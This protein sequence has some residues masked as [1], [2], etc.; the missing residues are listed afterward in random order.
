MTT[1]TPT[2]PS[3]ALPPDLEPEV[4][5]LGRR[6]GRR[7]ASAAAV[8]RAANDRTMALVAADP[9]LRAAL[10]RLVD[11]APAC[12]GNEELRAH[13]AAYL[14]GIEDPGPLASFGSRAIDSRA[15]GRASG[16][17][18]ATMVRQM[19]KRFIVGET[20]VDAARPIERIWRDGATVTVD[21]LGEATVTEEEGRAYARRCD[22]ALV[23]LSRHAAGW[24]DRP[25][26]EA[27]SIG[28]IPRVNLSVKVTALTPL[29]RAAAPERG[30]ADAVGRLR[31]LMRRAAGLGAHLHVDM[32]SMDSREMIL[33]LVLDLLA[34]PEFAA[35]PSLGL[36][37][38]AYLR[39]SEEMLE[40][41]LA[42]AAAAERSVPLTIRLVKGAYWDH[43]TIEAAQ[44]GW[45]P[46]VWTDKADSDRCFERLTRR[47]L[48]SYPL[49]RT[50]IASHNLRSVA[51]AAAYA[52]QIGL[53]PADFEIQVLRGLG[54]DLQ[55]AVV[56]AG[57]RCRV[58]C[59]VGDMVSG[60]AYLVRRLLENTS[61][62]SFLASRASGSDLDA[63]LGRP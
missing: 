61:N 36:V 45:A 25:A 13:L 35:G 39:D 58:Y 55:E 10:F 12:R 50:A 59:P 21:L 16:G 29:V 54:D 52:E 20:I 32:E 40:R 11:V 23:E 28:P 7:R 56:E 46:P 57:L 18:A 33:D 47:L 63:L 34:E 41:I 60:M 17:V 38:Q 15:L 8:K 26:V 48:D 4:L 42:R 53:G 30:R 1:L 6:L 9:E 43:E 62:A 14:E 37:L 5:E 2:R 24:A 19:A 31:E 22:E 44:H 3:P 51:Y 49:V 27:D